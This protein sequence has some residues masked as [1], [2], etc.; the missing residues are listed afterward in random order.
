MIV[1]VEISYY[2]LTESYNAAIDSFIEKLSEHDRITV[3]TGK[4]STIL[5]GNYG[6]FMHVLTQSMGELMEKNPS[7]FNLKI[8]NSCPG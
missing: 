8:S 4:M 6:E 3:E 2:P 5:I 7:V 1:T